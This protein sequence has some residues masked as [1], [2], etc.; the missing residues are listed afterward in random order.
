MIFDESAHILLSSLFRNGYPG[1]R[2][3]VIEKPNSDAAVDAEKRYLHVARKYLP[4]IWAQAWLAR[5]H[6]DACVI[7]EALAALPPAFY[8]KTENSTLRVLDYPAGAGTAEH[9]DFDLFTVN[10]W[11]STPEDHEQKDAR[12]D[13]HDADGWS[14]GAPAFHVGRIGE[15]VG[16]GPSVPHRVP[17]RDYEQKAIVYFAMPGNDVVFPEGI[18]D[19]QTGVYWGGKTV[20]EWVADVTS[21]SR[22]YK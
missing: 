22:V 3:N 16:L 13:V 7:A 17:A 2:P 9:T 14:I 5:A 18:I 10:L 19:P 1:Y 4:P 15:M 12:F 8:P 11:R 20:G 6:F 21:K